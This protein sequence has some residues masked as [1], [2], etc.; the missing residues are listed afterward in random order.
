MKK[1]RKKIKRQQK[2]KREENFWK[3]QKSKISGT[4]KNKSF[5]RKNY[6][7]SWQYI[8]GSKN[9]ILFIVLLFLL[10]F[11]LAIFYQPAEIVELIKDFIEEL[12]QRT[13]GLNTRQMIIFILNNNFKNS[14]IAMLLGIFLGIFPVFTA[15]ANGYVL[16]FV[17]E[18]SVQIEGIS[19]LWRL[20]PH[21]IFELPAVVLALGLGVRLGAFWFQRE[22]KKEFLSRLENSLRVFL[23]IILPL[24][25]I[26]AIIEGIL[27]FAL[28]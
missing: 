20:L 19:V 11:I 24:L 17:A 27:I 1:R 3:S 21:G 4:P 8:K 14:F 12:L 2:K 7:L 5:L 25:V 23:F 26:A 13:E 18:K 6:S 10:G 15:L 22:K 9:F 28:G 16:G